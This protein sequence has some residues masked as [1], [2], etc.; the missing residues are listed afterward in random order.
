MIFNILF[1]K[2]FKLPPQLPCSYE[3][4]YSSSLH[5]EFVISNSQRTNQRKVVQCDFCCIF[6]AFLF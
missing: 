3:F 1:F 4:I 5:P 2:F 6:I